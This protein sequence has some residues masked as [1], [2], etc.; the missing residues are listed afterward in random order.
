MNK[1]LIKGA[2]A[3][4]L[5]G[6]LASCHDDIASGSVIEGKLKAYEQVFREEFPNIDANHDWGFGTTT[7]NDNVTRSENANANEWADIKNS[8]GY[9]GWLVPD[10]LTPGQKERVKAY[11][12]A[13][14]NLTYE[15]PHLTNFF[16]QQVYTGYSSP[17]ANS[18]EVV[19]AA[20]GSTYT[21]ANMN[22]LTVGQNNVH[23]NNFN[24]GTATSVS[25][26]DNGSDIL[27][28]QTSYHSDQ[29][30]LMV[31]ID[32]TSCFGYHDT[33]SSNEENTINHNDRCALVSAAVI[34]A[35]AA[36]N[37]NPGAPVV[38]KW[39]RSFLGFDLAI[40]EGNQI[41]SSDVQ[42]YTTG[43]FKGFSHLY[44]GENNIVGL[45]DVD[46]TGEWILK[47]AYTGAMVDGYDREVKLLN[48]NTNFY[49]GDLVTLSES[50]L[51]VNHYRSDGTGEGNVDMLNMVK[52]TQMISDGYYPVSGSAFKTWVKPKASFD[53]YF[54]DWIVTLTD[55][56]RV[57]AVDPDTQYVPIDPTTT[58]TTTI[59]VETVTETWEQLQL[60]EQGRVFCEDLGRVT[61]ADID[62]NDVVFDAYIYR[63]TPVTRTIIK[64][65][66]V[67]FSR[68]GVSGTPT[69]YAEII[70]LAAGGTIPLSVAGTEV[71]GAFG[72][73]STTTIVN[74]IPTED[75]SYGNNFINTNAAVNLGTFDGISSISQIKI[76]VK[77][78]EE[79]YELGENYGDA[80]HK[81]CVK[82]IGTPWTKERQKFWDAYT[83][84]GAYVA[85]RT[86]KFWEGS[87]NNELIYQCSW[88][89]YTDRS[90]EI[91][92]T[93]KGSNSV[94]ST[95]QGS[96]T[97]TG[98]YQ[99]GEV[100]S[101][102]K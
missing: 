36:N 29:I 43:L 40:K 97:T 79:V 73:P 55:A 32:D 99:G 71:H 33:G 59:Q 37:G 10:P 62:F 77:L 44:Y 64:K 13:N 87:R 42:T 46:D 39:N 27:A 74:T 16:V 38:D 72:A 22:L 21:S 35:W 11:F 26:L 91:V 3:L 61:R 67:E 8:T 60:I 66:G 49:S 53:G 50:D 24:R 100:L 56:L 85:D 68:E 83:D 14:P 4:V 19:T 95:E 51:I 94:W 90:T 15:D 17:G 92:E 25:V 54:S 58:T 96:T 28:G 98:G 65:D 52:V 45:Y 81:I 69:Y 86:V 6:C 76:V 89:N 93:R 88:D 63:K 48:S 78:N 101:R 80:P 57:T 102:K 84:F 2:L 34:D 41:Y 1:F 31:D 75:E 30:M 18:T 47:N 7:S 5:G 82:K 9:G 23:I 12:Q 70:L 20:N